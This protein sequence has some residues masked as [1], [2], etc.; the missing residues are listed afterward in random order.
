MVIRLCDVGLCRNQ[1]TTLTDR[2]YDTCQ[3]V[4]YRKATSPTM[5]QRGLLLDAQTI[6]LKT[7]GLRAHINF[8]KGIGKESDLVPVVMHSLSY[9]SRPWSSEDTEPAHD[10]KCEKF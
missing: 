8:R 2:M 4:W 7:S 3:I 1:A 5:L 9:Y 6:M 10:M